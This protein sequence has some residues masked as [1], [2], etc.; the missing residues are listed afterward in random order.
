MPK[1]FWCRAFCGYSESDVFIFVLSTYVA[2]MGANAAF[3]YMVVCS[4]VGKQRNIC[5][6]E[7]DSTSFDALIWFLEIS[8]RLKK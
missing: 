8:T 7:V 2:F 1:P 6:A 3:T 5:S 4:Y